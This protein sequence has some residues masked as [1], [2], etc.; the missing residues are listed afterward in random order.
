MVGEFAMLSRI[1]QNRLQSGLAGW[2]VGALLLFELPVCGLADE[3]VSFQKLGA[4]F[5]ERDPPDP[6]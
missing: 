4:E 2:C 1:G 5:V 6:E 3:P